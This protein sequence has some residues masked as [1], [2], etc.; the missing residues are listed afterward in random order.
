MDTMDTMDTQK[1][2]GYEFKTIYI[3]VFKNECP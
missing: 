2:R 1:K 3:K